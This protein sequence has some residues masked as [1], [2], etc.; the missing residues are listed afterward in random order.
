MTID[1]GTLEG[2]EDPHYTWYNLTTDRAD[3]VIRDKELRKDDIKGG[4]LYR[5]TGDNI[6]GT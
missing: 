4:S 2:D 5:R 3:L 6:R 1:T